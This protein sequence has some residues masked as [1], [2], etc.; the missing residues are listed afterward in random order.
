MIYFGIPTI[1]LADHCA[2]LVESIY[3]KEPY[4][5]VVI[6][7]NIKDKAFKSWSETTDGI[8]IVNNAE[9][10]G[11]AR[12]WNQMLG[13]ALSRRDMEIFFVLNDDIIL[14]PDCPTRMIETIREQDYLAVSGAMVR[15]AIDRMYGFQED[16]IADR[17]DVTGMHFSC[18]AVTT[19]LLER[20][21]FFDPKYGLSYVEDT[22]YFYRMEKLGI[23][24]GC[25]KY[26]WFTHYRVKERNVGDRRQSHRTNREYFKRKWGESPK[27][28]A[29]RMMSGTR[30]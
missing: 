6:N 26:A 11:V 21:G 17:Y 5:V 8:L 30:I 4:K 28:T 7:N 12:S 2:R 18:F 24:K 29:K 10:L 19:E 3:C 14:H 9:N 23:K 25:D 13:W 16:M 27:A 15:G 1:N 20:V 22:D